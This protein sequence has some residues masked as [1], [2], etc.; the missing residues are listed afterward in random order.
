M[1]SNRFL[2]T[3]FSDKM[4]LIRLITAPVLAACGRKVA[5]KV[6]IEPIGVLLH[7]VAKN[8]PSAGEYGIR[9]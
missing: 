6:R 1:F 7:F 3:D 5:K 4:Q 9:L 8:R 2:L